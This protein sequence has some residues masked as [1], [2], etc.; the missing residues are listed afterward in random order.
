MARGKRFAFPT[1][2]PQA[3]GCPQAPQATISGY[4]ICNS[5]PTVQTHTFIG[6]DW[7]FGLSAGR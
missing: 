6:I 4:E 2:H 3:G 5:K 7:P 1:A